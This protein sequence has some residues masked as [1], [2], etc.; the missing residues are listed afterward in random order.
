MT[1]EAPITQEQVNAAADAL[2]AAGQKITNRAVHD[3]V[4]SGSMATIVK[5]LQSWKAAQIRTSAS[6]D[7]AIDTEVSRSISNMVA[8]RLKEAGA[9]LNEKVAELQNDLSSVIGECEKQ[10]ALIEAQDSELARLRALVQSQTGQ[11]EQLT[12]DVAHAREQIAV[13]IKNR[14]SAQIA[15]AKAELRI[16]SLPALLEELKVARAEAKQTG[17]EAAELRGKF[18]GLGLGNKAT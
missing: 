5:M 13:E 11:I 3:A 15:L 6:I 1:R 14:E 10:A 12:R 9:E 4:G 18:A 17:E 16:E 8:R 7:D 2:A